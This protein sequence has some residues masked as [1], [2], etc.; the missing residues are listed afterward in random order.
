MWVCRAHRLG[1]GAHGLRGELEEDRNL[2]V[3]HARRRRALHDLFPRAHTQAG[4]SQQYGGQG[5]TARTP[6]RNLQ[7]LRPGESRVPGDCPSLPNPK[8]AAPPP[9]RGPA[10]ERAVMAAT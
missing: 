8:G 5:V 6:Q 9:M 4:T 1:V 3:R 2:L 7:G 10:W